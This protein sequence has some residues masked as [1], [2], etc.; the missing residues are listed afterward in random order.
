MAVADILIS[1]IKIYTSALAVALPDETS[2]AA[3]ASWG[4]SWTDLGYTLGPLTMKKDDETFE[5]EVEQIGIPVKQI[6]SKEMVQIE[7]SLAELTAANLKIAFGS[8]STITT[9]AAGASQHGFDSFPFGGEVLLPEA[10]YGFEGYVLD[11]S[12]R[13]LVKRFF[14]YKA[15]ASMGGSLEFT[16]KAATGVPLRLTVLADTSKAAGAQLGIAHLVTAW[17]TS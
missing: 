1:P 4:G 5:L 11:S 17:K 13:Q 15:T 14:F 10:Q 16:K 7:V 3:G 9:M 8:T 2:V 6:R 12:N